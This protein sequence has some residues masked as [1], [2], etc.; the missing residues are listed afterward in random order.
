MADTIISGD[1]NVLFMVGVTIKQKLVKIFKEQEVQFSGSSG[2]TLTHI[3]QKD[4]S[5]VDIYYLG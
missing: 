3:N 5:G 2:V 1:G 4:S